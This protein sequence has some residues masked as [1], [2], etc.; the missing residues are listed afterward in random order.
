M[1]AIL[2][3]STF[4]LVGNY[5]MYTLLL[6]GCLLG[7]SGSVNLLSS[8]PIW[9]QLSL[10][11]FAIATLIFVAGFFWICWFHY[12]IYCALPLELPVDLTQWFNSHLTAMNRGAEYGLP[13]LDP[14]HPPRY[15]VPVWIENEKYYFWFM[16]YSIM[17]FIAH[18]RIHHHRVRALLYILFTVQVLILFCATDPFTNP[19]PGFFEEIRPWFESSLTQ[20]GKL[21]LFM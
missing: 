5:L 9:N 18:Y 12:Q 6:M 15:T 4:S 16:C 8:R 14:L 10:F 11:I 2:G 19:L 21:G 7:L 20:R 1:D 3:I 17:A 13:L